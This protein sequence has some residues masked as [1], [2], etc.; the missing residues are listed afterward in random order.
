MIRCADR[1]ITYGFCSKNTFCSKCKG[2][3]IYGDK[4]KTVGNAAIS[5]GM[6]WVRRFELPAS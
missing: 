1:F 3:L 4:R 2:D 5:N 6:V